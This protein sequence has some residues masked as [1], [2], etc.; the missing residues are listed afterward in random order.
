MEPL[1]QLTEE[2]LLN[3]K[4]LFSQNSHYCFMKYEVCGPPLK[5][6]NG[7]IVGGSIP[8]GKAG[9]VVQYDCD[10]GW[11]IHGSPTSTC[12]VSGEWTTP[13]ECCSDACP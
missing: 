9:Q 8:F 13:P 1:S 6:D 5:I 12:Q 10:S 4:Y 7:Y 11:L 2:F 3:C